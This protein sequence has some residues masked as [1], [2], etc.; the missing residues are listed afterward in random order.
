VRIATWN[1]NGLG[2]R[3]GF[4]QH[5]LRARQPDVVALQELKLV[6]DKFPRAELEELGYGAVTHGQKSWNGV[7]VLSRQPAELVQCGLPGQ[8]ELGAR[9]LTVRIG[10]L[11]VSSVYI[12]NGKFVDHED[13]PKKLAWLDALGL[14]L[15]K[16]RTSAP[17]HV[18]G[19]DFNLCPA[20]IDS[21]NEA[22]LH[23]RIFHTDAERARF[24]RL[25]DGGLVDAFRARH[26][27]T[28]EFSWWDYRAGSF[29][30]RQGLRIDFLLATP[31]AATRIEQVVIDREYRKKQDGLIPSDHAPVYADLT[32]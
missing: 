11:H 2:A 20:G 14:H 17:A 32:A 3:L 13:F 5:W 30:K 12:P 27:D 21:W 24:A 7:A 1:I 16:Q 18:I 23:G 31:P 6:D 9:L 22:A 8:E 25:L 15:E 29:H 19:G 10:D 26:P 4:L 28:Q